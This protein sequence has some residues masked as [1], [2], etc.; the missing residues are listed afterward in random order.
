MWKRDALVGALA[1]LAAAFLVV[2]MA[3]AFRN[4][5]SPPLFFLV[6]AAMAPGITLGFPLLAAAMWITTVFLP[7]WGMWVAAAVFNAAVYSAT[8][9]ALRRTGPAKASMWTAVALWVVYL[10]FVGTGGIDRLDPFGD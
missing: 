1:G 2:G 5:D 6:A 4:A 7:P 9:V 8:W 10:V 3:W